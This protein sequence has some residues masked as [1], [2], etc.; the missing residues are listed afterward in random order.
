MKLKS[1][2]LNIINDRGFLNQATNLEGLDD[3]LHDCEIK[4]M[5]ASAYI[6]FDCTA[7][8]LHVGSLVMIML[9]RI[10]QHCGHRPI[11]LLGGATTKVGDP[12]GK[13]E[14]RKFL[15]DEAIRENQQSILQAFK[16]FLNFDSGENRAIVV[17]N[18]EWLEKISYI[19]FLRDVGKHYTVNRMLTLDSVKSRLEREQP[20]T[21]L[22]F[23]YSLMQGYDFAELAKRYDCRIQMGGS[24]Q[25][26]NIVSGV[27][28]GR[29]F[30]LPELFAVTTHLITTKSGKK[31]GKTENGAVWLNDDTLS[32]YDYWQYFRNTE[33]ADVFKFLK[34]FTDLDL[35]EI[36]ALEHITGREINEIK[37][38]LADEAT[39][40]CRGKEAA[41]SA[42][43]MAEDI[44]IRGTTSDAMTEVLIHPSQLNNYLLVDALV[45]TG[46]AASK[47]S[48]R[49][50]IEGRGARVN[51]V[52]IDDVNYTLKYSDF[53]D[54]YAKVSSGQKKHAKIRIT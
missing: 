17:D 23:S 9:L 25:W 31:M 29:R 7:K 44:F 52:I 38:K 14:A 43:K 40:L 2:F 1:K 34:L 24:D 47:G 50:L 5:P 30:G 39:T 15:D 51:G 11:V 10:F 20:L 12:T 6:G 13:D 37:V 4:K 18:S 32:H 8:S 53:S 45:E 41:I 27:D 21:Y 35:N 42:R 22:E 54:T 36:N 28:L 33:D 19:E 49:R 26:G 46:L 16:T 48:A 3:Y